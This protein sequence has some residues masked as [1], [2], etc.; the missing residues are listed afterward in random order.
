MSKISFI[1]LL[2]LHSKAYGYLIN[3]STLYLFA[4]L[5]YQKIYICS[6]TITLIK[7]KIMSFL[8]YLHLVMCQ[9]FHSVFLEKVCTI[10]QCPYISWDCCVTISTFQVLIISNIFFS[11]DSVCKMHML[12]A[13]MTFYLFFES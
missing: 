3:V 5:Y 4:T 1:L 13:F 2:V 7:D 6:Q 11:L 10:S 12:K 9:I 8:Q